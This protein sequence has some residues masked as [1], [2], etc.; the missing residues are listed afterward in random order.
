MEGWI[1][2]VF[3]QMANA[4]PLP[5]KERELI[6]RMKSFAEFLRSQ[7]GL[8]NVFVL[9]DEVSGATIGLS[10]WR[11]KESFERGM[12]AANGQ[13]PKT[14]LTREPPKLRWFTEL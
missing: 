5:G 1:K 8:V 4:E 2:V 10:I 7:P 6:E 13:P 12:K 11:D 3:L 9:R 14:P